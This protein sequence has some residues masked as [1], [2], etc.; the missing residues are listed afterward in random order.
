MKKIM[1]LAL[2]AVL[3]IGGVITVHAATTPM[4]PCT[5]Q[6]CLV[7]ADNNGVCDNRADCPMGNQKDCFVDA[8]N[9]G[10]CDN[11]ESCPMSNQKDCFVDANNDG[12]C[13]NRESCIADGTCPRSGQQQEACPR[14][15]N[16]PMGSQNRP[17]GG[18]GMGAARHGGNHHGK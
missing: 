14:Q 13:D 16:C 3:L 4:G 5:Q 12:A 7:D 8:N 11:R 1:V 17:M 9:D 15:E 6:E 10:T 2:A 18:C